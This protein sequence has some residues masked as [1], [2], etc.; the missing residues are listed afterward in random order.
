M[1]ET[2]GSVQEAEGWPPPARMS[3][4]RVLLPCSNWVRS[5]DRS[6]VFS[7]MSVN[8]SRKG[9]PRGGRVVAQDSGRS[10][11][12]RRLAQTVAH[13]GP[14]M[15]PLKVLGPWGLGGQT[16]GLGQEGHAGLCSHRICCFSP[17][18]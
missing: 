7:D 10:K 11:S 18:V 15:P 3:D 17:R 4:L 14:A 12:T 9:A 8:R 5:P 16:G 2:L 1:E 13:P 6:R